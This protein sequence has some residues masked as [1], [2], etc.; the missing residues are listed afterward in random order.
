MKNLISFIIV[1]LYLVY[2][3]YSLDCS[4]FKNDCLAC[5][6]AYENGLENFLLKKIKI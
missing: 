6:L 3:V 1:A 2:N 4:Q 5:S